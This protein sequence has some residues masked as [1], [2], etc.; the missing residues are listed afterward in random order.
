M[1]AVGTGP[2]GGEAVPSSPIQYEVEYINSDKIPS[3][4]GSGEANPYLHIKQLGGSDVKT[5]DGLP[6]EFYIP[7]NIDSSSGTP[8][9]ALDMQSPVIMRIDNSA[10][11]GGE[12]DYIAV[13]RKTDGSLDTGK[14]VVLTPGVGDSVAKDN[15]PTKPLNGTK[16]E[17]RSPVTMD[18]LADLATKVDGQVVLS[19]AKTEARGAVYTAGPREQ[20]V[21]DM[22]RKL[23]FT[24][25]T[26]A[27]EA[28]DARLLNSPIQ[29]IHRGINRG[30][31]RVLTNV[32][33]GYKAREIR[34]TA[35][36]T[37]HG[38]KRLTSTGILGQVAR[39]KLVGSPDMPS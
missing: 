15:T 30:I 10:A 29:R 37:A 27:Q 35:R 24:D 33:E 21:A 32:L 8:V 14:M 19:R 3:K 12:V 22:V 34:R 20:Y 11:A 2:T 28:V 26:T 9:A 17:M 13:P 23:G 16:S 4:G 38:L 18:A 6:V 1:N 36:I 39:G 31:Q 5:R 7:T 25:V